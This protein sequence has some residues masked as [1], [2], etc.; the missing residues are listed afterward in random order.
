M[1][2]KDFCEVI[3]VT[4]EIRLRIFK[5]NRFQ[6]ETMIVSQDDIDPIYLSKKI[7]FIK[8]EYFIQ[9]LANNL[10]QVNQYYLITIN[11]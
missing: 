2:L 11:I 7:D 3:P 4:A 1:L 10:I 6:E 5:N 8:Q 9:T